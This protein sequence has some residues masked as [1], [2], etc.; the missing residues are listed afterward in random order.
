MNNVVITGTG[1]Y[2]PENQLTNFDLESK[3]NTSDEWITSRT[4]IS[5]RRIA[6][7]YETPS[8]MATKAAENALQASGIKAND[9]D[10][11][12]VA[13]STPEHIF[14]SVACRVQH[15][16]GITNHAPAFDLSAACSGFLYVLDV[17]R[18][19]IMSGTARHV[20][21]IG[22]ECMSQ[23]MDW[24]DRA[25]CIL[26]GDGAGAVVLS[27]SDR[28]GIM[29]S[30]LHAS[31][32][33]T[34]LLTLPNSIYGVPPYLTM[35]GNELFKLAVNVMGKVVDEVLDVSQLKKSDIQWLIPHQANMRIIQAIAKKLDLPMSR[36][37]TTIAEQGNTSA[38]SVPL[39]LD[40]SI[41]TNKIKR[42]DIILLE[43][44]G[45]GMTWGAMAIRY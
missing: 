43:A 8:Y 24:S 30:V 19:Y 7:K 20:L 37:I 33:K 38:A 26:F 15:E 23:V 1:S 10:L 36:V 41:R 2:L 9:L 45:G 5:S 14:P 22:S 16:L 6:E 39:A 27:A 34:E 3:V 32:D 25:T 17:A 21:V 35:R 13:T 11:I 12:I 29:G 4:G 31:Y 28:T 40:H 42:D 18:Q 44:F